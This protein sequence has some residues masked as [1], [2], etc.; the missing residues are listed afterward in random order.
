MSIRHVGAVRR[1]HDPKLRPT[2]KLTLMCIAE[3]LSGQD[4]EQGTWVSQATLALD[5]GIHVR[6]LRTTI[7]RLEERGLLIVEAR[8]GQSCI[9]RIN[10]SVCSHTP[11]A[12]APSTPDAVA[13]P[14]RMDTPDPGRMQSPG[15]RDA[16]RAEASGG[17]G[18]THP[19]T[20]DAHARQSGTD[21][22][23][24]PSTPPPTPRSAEPDS[25]SAPTT[26]DRGGGGG[27]EFSIEESFEESRQRLVEWWAAHVVPIDDRV[28]AA[29]SVTNEQVRL[30]RDRLREHPDLERRVVEGLDPIESWVKAKITIDFVLKSKTALE[31]V[32]G[33]LFRSSDP[34]KR[35]ARAHARNL[36]ERLRRKAQILQNDPSTYLTGEVIQVADIPA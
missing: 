29:P 24:D 3:M 31:K 26:G 23:D 35:E 9:Y 21:P 14:P 7:R 27:E 15:V 30:F 19:G 8:S 18:W 22:E 25:G 1:L 20:P 36:Q 5:V 13:P 28:I 11:D 4:P 33:G 17:G 10:P 2:E 32:I 34:A 6:N 16:P 12:D